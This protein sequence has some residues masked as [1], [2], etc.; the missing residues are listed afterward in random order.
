MPG[1]TD[2]Q[3]PRHLEVQLRAT[4]YDGLPLRNVHVLAATDLTPFDDV[5]GAGWYLGTGPILRVRT[6]D[7]RMTF[8][9]LTSV[10]TWTA[11]GDDALPDE[12]RAALLADGEDVG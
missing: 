1:T 6:P 4:G 12:V 5:G 3:P 2:E 9:P 8:Y 11:V 7:D 10:L